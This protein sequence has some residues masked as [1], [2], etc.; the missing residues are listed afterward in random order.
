MLA[1]VILATV[2]QIARAGA[3]RV[4]GLAERRDA[5]VL[6]VVH[7]D[8][9]PDF[10]HPLRVSHR[11]RPV[12]RATEKSG[13]YGSAAPADHHRP[14]QRPTAPAACRARRRNPARSARTAPRSF[15]G[16]RG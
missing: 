6:V 10:R 2:E 3:E 16:P 15:S 8:I 12:R 5:A 13:A 14:I 4:V 9:E 1:A 11:A 7:A